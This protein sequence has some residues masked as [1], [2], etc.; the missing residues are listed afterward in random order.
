MTL[1]TSPTPSS[2]MG[3]KVTLGARDDE[4]DTEAKWVGRRRFKASAPKK[5]FQREEGQSFTSVSDKNSH[6]KSE[7]G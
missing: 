6:G 3:V 1:A 2:D 4:G 7:Y 5:R